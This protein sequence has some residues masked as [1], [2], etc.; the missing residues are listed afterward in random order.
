MVHFVIMFFFFFFWWWWW[1]LL[2]LGRDTPPFIGSPCEGVRK[3]SLTQWGVAR[4]CILMRL[5]FIQCLCLYFSSICICISFNVCVCI[6]VLFAFLFHS[7]SKATDSPVSYIFLLQCLF[8]LLKQFN[9][10]FGIWYFLIQILISIHF[11]L[12][13]FLFILVWCASIRISFFVSFCIFSSALAP[14]RPINILFPAIWW[15]TKR[16]ASYIIYSWFF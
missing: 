4:S 10:V 9:L 12:C 15:S 3:H 5:Y 8:F 14:Q 16:N 2:L 13:Y 11:I 7:H 6:S 1:Q